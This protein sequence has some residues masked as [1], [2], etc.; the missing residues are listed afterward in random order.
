MIPS[1]KMSLNCGLSQIQ[2]LIKSFQTTEGIT[3]QELHTN[4]KILGPQQHYIVQEIGKL[5]DNQEH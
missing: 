1:R 2:F 4:I 5:K 3:M